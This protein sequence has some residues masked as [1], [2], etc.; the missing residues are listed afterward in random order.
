MINLNTTEI[1]EN[2]VSIREP[3]AKTTKTFK[4]KV[5]KTNLVQN[6]RNFT[7]KKISATNKINEDD[8]V[9]KVKKKAPIQ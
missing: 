4:Y 9:A 5:K 3:E 8:K 7:T 6:N 1:R 2:S